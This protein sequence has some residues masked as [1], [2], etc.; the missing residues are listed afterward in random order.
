MAG[1]GAMVQGLATA[2]LLAAGPVSLAQDALPDVASDTLR[3]KRLLVQDCGSCHGL[4]MKGGL[5]PALTPDQLAGKPLDS[6]VATVLHGRPG[7]A[8]PPWQG[9]LSE[10]EAKWMVEQLIKGL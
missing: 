6:L 9:L 3:L 7:T 4:Q 2:L 1:L 10:S 8:M 5:G